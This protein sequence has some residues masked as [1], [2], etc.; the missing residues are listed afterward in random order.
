[1]A[2][3]GSVLSIGSTGTAST[4]CGELPS[5]SEKAAVAESGGP[6]SQCS[7]ATSA[8][9]QQ[10]REQQEA[11][12]GSCFIPPGSYLEWTDTGEQVRVNPVDDVDA[13]NDVLHY[14]LD[15]EIDHSAGWLGGSNRIDAVA[16]GDNVTLFHFRLADLFTIPSIL[17][18]GA[19]ASWTRLDEF[20]VEVVL[21]RAY[22][23]GEPFEITVY[24]DGYPA[25]RGWGSIVYGEHN[26]DPIVFTLSEPWYAYTW[27]PAKDVNTDKT[28]AD[29]LYTVPS[30]MSV[31]SNG[32]LLSTDDLGDGRT[33]Y[34]WQTQYPTVTYLYAFT[35]TN[36]NRFD[37]VY[38]YGEGTMPCMFFLYPEKDNGGN[39]SAMRKSITMMEVFRPLFGL[40]PFI[41]EK[42]GICQFGW[43]GGMEHQTITS[44]TSFSESLTAHELAHQWWGDMVTCATWEDIWLNEGFATYSEALWLE[45]KNGNSRAALLNAMKDLR[46]GRVDGS[47][48]CYD[49]WNVN[50]IFSTSFTY[51]KAAW[52]LHMLRTVIGDDDFFQTLA[53]YR[54]A[55]LYDSA[56]TDQFKAVAERVCGRDLAWFFDTWVYDWGAPTYRYNWRQV[57]AF[58]NQY[59]EL[60]IHQIQ[61]DLNGYPDFPMPVN[62]EIVYG[63][64]REVTRTVW[65]DA[66]LE[67]LLFEVDGT[68]SDVRFDPEQL[69]LWEGAIPLVEFVEGPPHVVATI[70]VADSVSTRP[71]SL[72]RI[73]FQKD[74]DVRQADFAV[75]G[76]VVGPVSFVAT[77]RSGSGLATLTFSETL[78]DD[79]YTLTVFDTVAE[80]T[81]GLA[82]DGEIGPYSWVENE[83]LLPSGDGEPGGDCVI[84]FTVDTSGGIKPV[85]A[86]PGG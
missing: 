58:G 11:L 59:L 18:N 69:I 75:V 61:D 67:H 63:D 68:V 13:T 70:P 29:L 14:T 84:R 66:G 22:S 65:N 31:A 15:I 16:V 38:D 8:L 55:Y 46:P 62:I 60:Y 25:S 41:D 3:T 44:Q 40:Y 1:M 80:I 78:P 37:E 48:Y 53:E 42:Y 73:A 24:Y 82:L 27:W 51:L 7:R 52:V 56:T 81:N 26:H 71:V 74:V 47:V 9:A 35:A 5:T 2:L 20:T 54:T 85:V 76:D 21:D 79:V 64:G 72:V 43:H 86:K 39:R 6:W 49:T 34:H 83:P 33:Q 50:R 28:T 32:L 45:N 17:I 10:M 12:Y 36:F 23:D 4:A 30:S 19:E 57:G 77:Y